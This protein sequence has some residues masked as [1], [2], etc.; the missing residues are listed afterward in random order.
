LHARSRAIKVQLPK[1][2]PPFLPGLG[3]I[4]FFVKCTKRI[5]I[6]I[7]NRALKNISTISKRNTPTFYPQIFILI[8]FLFRTNS[9]AIIASTMSLLHVTCHMLL[10]LLFDIWRII[11]L[12]CF[13]Q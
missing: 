4:T 5:T 11:C 9:S 7:L 12:W 3:L 13:I 6:F 8:R 1:Y 2:S 10:V